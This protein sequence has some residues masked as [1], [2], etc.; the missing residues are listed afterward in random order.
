MTS[1]T[2]DLDLASPTDP[3]Y[4]P[5][6]VLLNCWKHHVGAIRSRIDRLDE[7]ALN[8]LPAQL[9]RIGSELMD[10]YHGDFTPRAITMEVLDYLH[11]TSRLNLD[12]YRIWLEENRGYQVIPIADSSWVLRMGE[13][14]GRYV[15]VHPGRWAPQ[16]RR[17]RANVLKT[18]IMVM[19]YV[20]V[21]GGNP[22]SKKLVNYVRQEY[23][24]LSPMARVTG[25]EGLGAILD[26]L[27]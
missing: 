27:K 26:L 2:A 4:V 13:E 10:L 19:G 20:H 23:L 9:V 25:K 18:A 7:D 21:K 16:T 11:T 1:D 6:P 5:S 3:D 22:T 8:K 15:H 17:V 12:A 24:E 14:D